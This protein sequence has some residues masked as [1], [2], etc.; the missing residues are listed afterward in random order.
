MC[1]CLLYSQFL[2]FSTYLFVSM[3]YFNFLFPCASVWCKWELVHESHIFYSHTVWNLLFSLSW[4]WLC[5]GFIKLNATIKL[6]I[7]YS[8]FK[9]QNKKIFN[10]LLILNLWKWAVSLYIWC[11]FILNV[12]FSLNSISG[13]WVINFW[14]TKTRMLRAQWR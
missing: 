4:D 3:P 14:A 10:I 12:L 2:L 1:V 7:I 8:D 13:L 5:F 6:I 9:L 11:L